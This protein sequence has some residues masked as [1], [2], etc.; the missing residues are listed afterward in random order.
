YKNQTLIVAI[1]LFL[2]LPLFSQYPDSIRLNDI[3]IIASHNSY[4]R[5]PDER[6]IRFLQKFKKRLGNELDPQRMNYGHVS[7]SE[8]FSNYAIRGIELDIYNDPHGGHYEKRRINFF[9]RGLKQHARDSLMRKPGFKV[10][11]IADVDY[12]SNYR[13]FTE[14]LQDIRAWSQNNPG[15]V[16][17]FINLEL[18]DDAPADY[19]HFL[20]F[21]GFKRAVDFD[22]L[23]YQYLDDDIFRSFSSNQILTPQ[24]LRDTFESVQHRIASIGWP[25]LNDVLGKVIFILDGHG[26]EYY[27]YSKHSLAFA[28]GNP[29]H[30]NTAF[31]IRNN[32]IGRENEIR[33]LSNRFIIRTRT[34]VETLQARN[35]DY[36]MFDAAIHSRAQILSTDYYTPDV[37]LS[38]YFVS[39]K[40]VQKENKHAFL[41]R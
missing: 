16:P 15:H 33:E 14:A 3:R 4:K 6:V 31:V 2:K 30:A 25:K 11:H 5:K 28:Y 21:L 1:F 29:A 9:I 18:K 20:R 27:R 26:D 24:F 22:S 34:D 37:T 35:N 40:N 39:F 17:I 38:G 7:L 10:L 41:L 12:E 13:T 23:S 32:P 8:Q 19:S 36:T